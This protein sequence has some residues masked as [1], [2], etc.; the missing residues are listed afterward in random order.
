MRPERRLSRRGCSIIIGLTLLVSFLQS[1]GRIA[2]DTKLDLT[3]DPVGFL[4][5][6]AHLWSSQAPLGQVQ[7]QAYGYFFPHGAFFA[8]GDVVG[9]PG[10]VTQRLWWATLL[11]IG[12]IG[13]V[14][15]AEALRIGSPGSRL[16]AAAAFALSPRVLTTLGSISSETLPMMLAPWVLAPVVSAF[17]DPGTRLSLRQLAFRSSLAVALMG[18][19]NAAATLAAVMPALIWWLTRCRGRGRNWRVFT[20]WWALGAVLAC[21]WWLVPLV[22]LSRVS[23]PFLDFI[24]SS[25]VTTEWTSL[26]E[27]LRGT[28]SWTPFVS[29]ERVA[30][31]VLV[32]QPAAVVVTGLLATAGLVGLSMRRM[33]HRGTLVLVAA[34]GLLALCSGFAGELGSPV[35]E[36]VRQ[37]LD[38]VGAPLRNVHKF[39]PMIR[40]PLVLGIAHLLARAPLPGSVP[41][42]TAV[43][44]FARPERRPV[45]AVAIAL[46][47][48]L[49]GSGS[50]VWTGHL[51]PQGSYDSVPDYWSQTA[52]WLQDRSTGPGSTPATP[53]RALVVPGSPFADQ[54]WGLTRDEPLQGLAGS[55]WAVRDAIPLVPPEAIR[56][57]DAVE[58]DIAAGRATPG[59]ATTLAGQGVAFVVLRADL[60]P[61]TSRSARP[62][63][64]QQA[65]VGSPGLHRV[66]R[67]GP[68]VG[69]PPV[70]G[71]VGDDGLRP[72]MPAVQI[73]A[74][75][76]V[77]PRTAGGPVVGDL[78]TMPRVDGG[79][80]AVARR[81][82]L[83]AAESGASRPDPV[84][85]S[86]DARAAGLPPTGRGGR[87]VTDTPVARETDF[88][89]VDDHSSAIRA[90]DDARQTQNA[91]PDYPVAGQP[92]TAAQWS[93]DGTPGAVSVSTSGSAADAT[94]LGQTAPANAAAAAFD[95]NPGTAWVSRGLDSA[96]GQ[97]MQVNFR[98]PRRDLSLSIT[99]GKALGPAVTGLL[100]T[101]EAGTTVAQ[102]ISPGKK[103]TVAAPSG[104]TRWVQV[105][106]I[107]TEDNT[108]GNQFAIAELTVRDAL[109][110]R[111]LTITHRTVLPELTAGEQVSGWLL[112]QDLDGRAAC[113][114]GTDETRCS[115]ALSLIAEEPGTFRRVL[116]VPA[117]TTVTPRV[118]L[119]SV[120]GGALDALLRQP[121][122]MTAS[123]PALVTD[124]RGNAS[125]AVDGDPSTVWTAPDS[126]TVPGA[127][128]PTVRIDLD[129]VRLIDGVRI[130]VP[131]GAYPAHPTR[132]AVDLGDGRQVRTIP[133]EGV[134]A[135]APAR[136]DHITVTV[137]DSTDLVDVNS[138]GFARP[139]PVGLAEV[140]PTGPDGPVPVASPDAPV[141]IGCGAGIG[142]AV[143]GRT[144]PM[145]VTTTRR[146]LRKQQPV[147]ATPCD[148]NPVPLAAGSQELSVNPG[149]GFTVQAVSLRAAS[150]PTIPSPGQASPPALQTPP[151]PVTVRSW[152]ADR[153]VLDVPATGN[154]RLLW[155]PEAQNPG[156]HATVAGR[157]LT[158]TA[159][160]GWQQA[161]VVPAGVGGTVTLDYPL[162]TPYRWSLRIG[163][164]LVLLVIAG[165]F[166]PSRRG[167][168]APV[169]TADR[170]TVG[171]GAALVAVPVGAWVLCGW[172]GLAASLISGGVVLAC[173]RWGRPAW[174]SGLVAAS[175]S[176]AAVALATAP[177]GTAG[178]AG[179]AWWSQ[180]PALVAVCLVGWRAADVSGVMDVRAS[181][182]R[183]AS[184]LLSHRRAGSSTSP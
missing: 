147:V 167:R 54:V 85:M 92:D 155:L 27:V 90:P 12:V 143:S 174:V 139:A 95:G 28:S 145:T 109:A 9:L 104:P 21:A 78:D 33:P 120:P 4:S 67:F 34:I 30:G 170:S 130:R 124:P 135:L 32:G 151:T 37:F 23:P 40:I 169:S 107:S 171:R 8:L 18:A 125:A 99:P 81:D 38:G 163:L 61:A 117:P 96:V 74:V 79:A 138:L 112:G 42:R 180:L 31:S 162:D 158:P 146:A 168:A 82:D 126:S 3:A 110:D 59:L 87:I 108:A 159:V 14:R 89:R 111:P 19:V 83:L 97:W 5:R 11:A 103:T 86:A 184:R 144:V 20:G 53:A 17:D 24:E 15:L 36:P 105:R 100:I 179:F 132:V 160:N 101:T 50:L 80:E 63:L 2:A 69:P 71:F 73:F 43:S 45:V 46:T 178:Y 16:F 176:A 91:A 177:W 39:D 136:T 51:A 142:L 35:A 22:I 55:P 156:W 164:P 118:V 181:V 29:P 48:A 140:T 119:R 60:S 58:R 154:D 149:A 183:W 76:G 44:A 134:I 166:W 165:A 93:L 25:R 88:G 127:G 98:D 123:A 161:W 175:S 121:D 137:L 68:D 131:A 56:A 157:E 84:L 153:R 49:V 122:T 66:A 57:M 72:R 113:V 41:W 94:Q 1:P 173:V 133:A 182:R 47:V 129:H 10:W 64:A 172:G 114:D 152:T 77:A 150:S 62:L 148:S 65:L 141:T 75:D 128:A 6:A 13:I 106:A 102:G 52:R 26:P 70:R 7:N 116:S 115:G